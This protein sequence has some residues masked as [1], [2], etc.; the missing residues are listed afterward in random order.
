LNIEEYISSGILEAYVLG[1]L[2][3]EERA[4]VEKNL[5]QYPQLREELL[6]VEEAQEKF[7][8]ATAVQPNPH[9]RKKVMSSIRGEGTPKMVLSEQQPVNRWPYLAAACL[10]FALI[11]SYLAYNYW[12]KWRDVKSNLDELIAQN[13]QMARDYDRVNERIDKI[14]EDIKVIDNPAFRR[15][16][17]KGTLNSPTSLAFV[18]WNENTSEVFLS[19]QSLKTL[20]QANQYQLWAIVDDK[21]VDAGTFD[22]SSSGLIKMKNAIGASAFAITI[23]P[24]GGKAVPTLET[25]QVAG[26]V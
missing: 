13:Q 7:L 5:L 8:L 15:I 17:M 23:E 24:R 12:H 11:S 10:V 22:F 20:S 19:V 4:D 25:M 21:P 3:P 9:V 1:D 16:I 6:R 18:Y 26:S 14:E 2:S